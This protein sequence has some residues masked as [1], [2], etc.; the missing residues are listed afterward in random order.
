MTDFAPQYERNERGWILFPSDVSRRKQLFVLESMSHTAKANIYMVEALVEYC[1]KPGDAVMDIFGGT[2]TLMVGHHV[3]RVVWL[4]ELNPVFVGLIKKN[5]AKVTADG[6]PLVIFQEGACQELLKGHSS[7]QA[8][9]TSPPYAGT[10]GKNSANFKE[11]NET[12][13][14]YH[15]SML[16]YIDDSKKRGNLAPYNLA[17]MTNFMFNKELE[18]IYKLS[19][20]VIRAGGYFALI[21]KDRIKGGVREELGMASVQMM[22]KIGF[23]IDRWERWLPPGT[24]FAQMARTKGQV[25]VD[26]EQLIIMRRP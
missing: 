3:G 20:D 8:I 22:T 18:K 6:P 4:M 14:R 19:F 15:Q 21:I 17:A 10:F 2:G 12:E 1:S 5:I 11:M 16:T 23:K 25:W 7:V 26:E 9:I 13:L 24:W